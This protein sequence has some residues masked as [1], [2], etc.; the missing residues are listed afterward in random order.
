VRNSWFSARDCGDEA[1]Q[2]AE[3]IRAA[4]AEIAIPGIS[5]HGCVTCTA[6]IGV[7]HPF[8][9]S[10]AFDVALQQAD[11]ALYRGKRAGRN[12]VQCVDLEDLWPQAAQARQQD[13]APPSE[14][15]LEG[16]QAAITVTA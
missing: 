16:A 3:R 2:L 6:T 10:H 5:L 8:V 12:R 4:I 15:G 7:S 14:K 1:L 13:Q 9:A 11:A